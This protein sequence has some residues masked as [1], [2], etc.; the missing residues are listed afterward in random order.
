M[1][2]DHGRLSAHFVVILPPQSYVGRL[3]QVDMLDKHGRGPAE[4]RANRFDIIPSV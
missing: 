1:L 4:L 3:W 2:V